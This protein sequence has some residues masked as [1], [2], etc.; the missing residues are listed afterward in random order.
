MDRMIIP[1][2]LLLMVLL[3]ICDEFVVSSPAVVCRGAITTWLSLRPAACDVIDPLEDQT[4]GRMW[5]D[6]DWS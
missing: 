3:L 6:T 1:F 4:L 2:L 5:Y